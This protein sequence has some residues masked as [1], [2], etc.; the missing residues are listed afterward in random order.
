M[1][2]EKGISRVPCGAVLGWAGATA[3][4][5]GD[6]Q[7]SRGGLGRWAVV[8]FDV[9]EAQCRAGTRVEGRETE[10]KVPG[11]A[12]FTEAGRAPSPGG[13]GWCQG[14]VSH[15]AR[16]AQRGRGLGGEGHC[17]RAMADGCEDPRRLPPCSSPQPCA[18][19]GGS[20]THLPLCGHPVVTAQ[21]PACKSPPLQVTF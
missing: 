12:S 4:G 15:G 8:T 1:S 16:G 21:K 17:P 18:C 2:R 6:A 5:R 14:P 10:R 7:C 13:E 19:G 11:R 20:I 9:Q 3:S